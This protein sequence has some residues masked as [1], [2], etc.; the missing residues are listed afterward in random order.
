M[1]VHPSHM[2]VQVPRGFVQDRAID[3]R[4]RALESLREVVRFGG[5]VHR[6]VDRVRGVYSRVG[7]DGVRHVL[8]GFADA[9]QAPA[10]V[11]TEVSW[12]CRCRWRSDHGI[13]V[14]RERRVFEGSRRSDCGRPRGRRNPTFLMPTK[15][16]ECKRAGVADARLFGTAGERTGRAAARDG[17]L[18]AL[19]VERGRDLCGVQARDPALLQCRN[20]RV[21]ADEHRH[22]QIRPERGGELDSGAESNSFDRRPDHGLLDEERSDEGQKSHGSQAAVT[23][24]VGRR[25]HVERVG[26][27]AGAIGR[28]LVRRLFRGCGIV[29][30]EEPVDGVC[31]EEAGGCGSDFDGHRARRAG[32]AA[33]AGRADFVRADSVRPNDLRLAGAPVLRTATGLNLHRLAGAVLL[34]AATGLNGQRL[35]SAVLL[36]ATAG[37]NGQRLAGG[38]PTR[39]TPGLGGLLG[40]LAGLAAL[41]GSP[42]LLR[43]LAMAGTVATPCTHL[44]GAARTAMLRHHVAGRPLLAT[45]RRLAAGGRLA[46]GRLAAALRLGDHRSSGLPRAAATALRLGRDRP[47]CTHAV[48]APARGNDA[49]LLGP[50]LGPRRSSALGGHLGLGS[51]LALGGGAL[52]S[53]ATGR[54]LLGGHGLLTSDYCAYT[55]AERHRS[56]DRGSLGVELPEADVLVGDVHLACL[57][58]VALGPLFRLSDGPADRAIE[59]QRLRLH[60]RPLALGFDVRNIDGRSRIRRWRGRG[61]VARDDRADT[62]FATMRRRRAVRPQ[63]GRSSAGRS[64]RASWGAPS[65]TFACSGEL[66]ETRVVHA[67]VFNVDVSVPVRSR[68]VNNRF[69]GARNPDLNRRVC[70]APREKVFDDPFGAFRS[71]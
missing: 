48:R 12:P 68:S 57:V 66:G 42:A 38:V 32:D 25:G 14:H 18:A 19:H 60:G 53:G 17:R 41:A 9:A 50:R 27:R 63:R 10:M 11:F 46:F 54:L 31:E 62:H 40:R 37:L 44:A 35:A 45:M 5:R 29:G 30:R 13:G 39:T 51:V 59:E 34:R 61:A 33:E 8:D 21:L 52:G 69:F 36:R 28:K 49:R 71:D 43:G 64:A 56:F 47:R 4:Q 15:A 58:S 22:Q 65:G 16:T 67:H 26:E 70:Y 7:R 2:R 1:L 55:F 20:A 23:E 6:G 24:Q 3:V